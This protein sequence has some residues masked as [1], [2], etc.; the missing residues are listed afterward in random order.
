MAD[1]KH[2]SKSEEDVRFRSRPRKSFYKRWRFWIIVFL[3]L[4]FGTIGAYILM[5]EKE[6]RNIEQPIEKEAEQVV[7]E[8]GEPAARN[9]ENQK[10]EKKD[11]AEPLCTYEDFKGTYVLFE[12]NPYDS[13]LSGM[14]DIIVLSEDS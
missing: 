2:R 13:P 1:K 5:N 9:A 6:G 4:L 14:S 10:S 3:I 12:G 11:I 8:S 7:E